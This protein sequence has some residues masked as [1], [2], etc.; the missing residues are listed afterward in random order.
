M[1]LRFHPDKNPS[2]EANDKFQEILT[3]FRVL[4]DCKFLCI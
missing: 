2:A 3:A 1:A 4:S